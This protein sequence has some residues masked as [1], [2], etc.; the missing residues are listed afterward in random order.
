VPALVNCRNRR[1][2][3][4]AH[5]REIPAAGYRRRALRRMPPISNQEQADAF[6]DAVLD[7]LV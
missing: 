2:A 5:R 1:L 7:F 4:A 6:S 3:D